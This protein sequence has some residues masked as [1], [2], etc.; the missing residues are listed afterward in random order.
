MNFSSKIILSILSLIV[1]S[2]CGGGGGSDWNMNSSFSGKI[3]KNGQTYICKSQ[4]AYD[5]CSS[6]ANS[7]CSACTLENSSQELVINTSCTT[8]DNGKTYIISSTGC[9]VP[10]TN[11]QVGVCT[12][13]NLRLLTGSGWTRSQVINSGS[14]FSRLG[15]TLNGT[16]IKCQ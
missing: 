15:L 5:E 14:S 13:T 1:L 8:P 16:V 4:K 7:D 10:L 6:S 9:I 12:P 2:A 3:T 11:V